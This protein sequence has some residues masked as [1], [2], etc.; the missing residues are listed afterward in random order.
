MDLCA[1]NVLVT[2]DKRRLELIFPTHNGV[3][4]TPF[5]ASLPKSWVVTQELFTLTLALD[6]GACECLCSTLAF[7]NP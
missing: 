6:P 5:Y 7:M 2:Y 1:G 3:T 4:K